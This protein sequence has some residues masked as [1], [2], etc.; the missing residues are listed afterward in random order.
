MN[1][2]SL[3]SNVRIS[4]LQRLDE[5][6]VPSLEV[7]RIVSVARR[8]RCCYQ[9]CEWVDRRPHSTDDRVSRN[10]DHGLVESSVERNGLHPITCP[11]CCDHLANDI[12]EAV[13]VYLGYMTHSRSRRISLNQLSRVTNLFDVRF[14]EFSD[15]I[16]SPRESHNQ[17]ICGQARKR[18]ADRRTADSQ[19][20]G[21]IPF[22]DAITGFHLT[23]V[24]RVHDRLIDN[25]VERAIRNRI[26]RRV[27]RAK[28]R[29][30]LLPSSRLSTNDIP[31][32]EM[33]IGVVNRSNRC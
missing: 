27:F 33:H 4:R 17:M 25:V 9:P 2:E 24:N 13:N 3:F 15:E 21:N 31:T 26:T 11:C 10:I 19:A 7:V 23:S 20:L 5:I 18:F 1:S 12:L 14:L 29:S 8:N 16:S 28:C 32:I 6:T 22:R 30:H